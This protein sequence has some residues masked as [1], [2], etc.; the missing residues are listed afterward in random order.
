MR[1]KSE[2]LPQ[3]AQGKHRVVHGIAIGLR[4]RRAGGTERRR[5]GLL[6]ALLVG[7]GVL[8][9]SPLLMNAASL[10]DIDTQFLPFVTLLAFL[11]LFEARGL[12]R[13]PLRYWVLFRC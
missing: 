3:R 12:V 9:T 7:L 4:W 8:L 1:A 10:P 13:S 6:L 11:I 2:S 5:W